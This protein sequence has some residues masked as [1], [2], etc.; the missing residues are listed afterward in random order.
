MAKR[1]GK[2][3]RGRRVPWWVTMDLTPLY[4]V[5]VLA[6]VFASAM[7][8]GRAPRNGSIHAC[9]DAYAAA[10]TAA[11][12]ERVDAQRPFDNPKMRGIRCGALRETPEYARIRRQQ[13]ERPARRGHA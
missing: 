13:A 6:S 3:P 7:L 9:I 5:A 8:I 1:A 4:V 12:S 10:T 11:D 2:A